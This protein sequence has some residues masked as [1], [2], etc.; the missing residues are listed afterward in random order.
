MIVAPRPPSHD[1]L[2]ALIKE[3]RERQLRRRLLVAASVAIAGAVGLA[4][5]ALTIGGQVAARPTAG[6]TPGRTAL[7]QPS[8]LTAASHW[9]GA[10]G[11]LINFFSIVSRSGSACS[12][13]LGQPVVDLSRRGSP[14]S[15]QESQPKDG[16][17]FAP[18][19]KPVHV[20]APGEKAAVYMQWSNW[21]GR[22]RSGLAT[23]VTV[24]FRDGLRVTAGQPPCLDR[25][26]PSGLVVSRVLTPR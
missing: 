24:L 6:A 25:A 7:C 15:V 17:G 9:N 4:V 21:C 8:Q 1:E 13:P 10:A 3:A 2:E 19:A 22:P 23:T 16:F 18:G 26:E 14:L 12:L 20:L 5:Y 11:T